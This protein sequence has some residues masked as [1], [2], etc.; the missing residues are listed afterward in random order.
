M[1]RVL[2]SAGEASGD[3][4][5]AMLVRQLGSLRPG[6]AFY[7]CAGPEMRNAGVEAVVRAEDLSVVGLM[8]VVAHIP[9]IWAKYRRLLKRARE[10]PPRLAILTDSPDFN[11]RLA[12]RL[13]RRGV[14]VVYLV[15]PQVWAWRKGRLKAMRRDLAR[16]FC[17][18]PFEEEFFR[19]RGLAAEYIGHPLAGEFRATATREEFFQAHRLPPDRP[20]VVLLPGSRRGEAMRHL[21]PLLDAVDLIQARKPASFAWAAPAGFFTEVGKARAWPKFR[22]RISGSSIQLIEGAT[23]DALTHAD[24]ALA[25]SGTVT[26]EAA[27]AGTPMVTYYRVTGLSWLAGKFLVRVPFYSMVNLIAGRAVA[28]ELMQNEVTG[29]RLAAE[30]MRLLGDGLAR[31]R[32][33]E[34]LRDVAARLARREKPLQ[35]AARRI[36]EEFLQER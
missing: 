15:A 24:L 19:A 8:E 6:L 14:P 29:P 36:E 32:M 31:E 35:M 9:R 16:L 11:L 25:A 26:V 5:A 1:D 13:R 4:Y 12:A 30:A 3:R 22:E 2:V 7:G 17:I 20:L 23:W 33:R 18:F 10:D 27:L 28:P 21:P 34:E